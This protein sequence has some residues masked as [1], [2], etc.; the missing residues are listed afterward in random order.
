MR[1]V[2]MADTHFLTPDRARQEWDAY[3][4]Q[5]G[6]LWW[7]RCLILEGEA[8]RESLFRTVSALAPDFILHCG[9]LTECGDAES[10]AMAREFAGRFSCP[11]H[12][13][14]G[15]H[16]TCLDCEALSSWH[17]WPAGRSYYSFS[18]DGLHV[19]MLDTCV[20]QY[21]D[22][23]YGNSGSIP[24]ARY[25]VRPEQLEWL[26]G[27]LDAHRDQTVV[28]V[29]HHALAINPSYGKVMSPYNRLL[30]RDPEADARNG[31]S[32]Q[33]LGNRGEVLRLLSA[34]PNVRLAFSG[35][36]HINDLYCMDGIAHCQTG[37]LHEY[38]LE[39]RLVTVRDGVMTVTT[40]GLNESRFSRESLL[41]EP[42][43]SRGLSI[44]AR[45]HAWVA[46]TPGDR[47]FSVPC[48][49]AKKA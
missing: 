17:G 19:V 9:D 11:F 47:E 40:H 35:H 14:H 10:L 15:N 2:V 6:W 20:F 12:W 7:N 25:V 18:A 36:W 39:F 26:R 27:D 24:G 45:G 30:L 31:V 28:A 49:I 23:S 1:F 8:I 34:Y 42:V 13:V 37:A 22:G 5:P 44:S 46:G 3:G 29:S 38:P 33:D 48:Q 16:D 41:T 32:P 43:I 4:G 21:P